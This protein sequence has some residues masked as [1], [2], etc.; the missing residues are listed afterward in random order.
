MKSRSSDEVEVVGRIALKAGEKADHDAMEND[1]FVRIPF[2]KD[3]LDEN[4]V[5]PVDLLEVPP[6]VRVEDE[7]ASIFLDAAEDL[8]SGIRRHGV[9]SQNADGIP[10]S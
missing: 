4:P 10:R 2:E 9:V 1:V 7:V 3:A 6:C 5:F 8:E